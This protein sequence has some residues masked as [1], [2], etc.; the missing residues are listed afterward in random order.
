MKT[1]EINVLI[2]EGDL[3]KDNLDDGKLRRVSHFHDHGDDT[4]SVY[5]TDGGV[6]GL[7]EIS[8]DDIE[9]SWTDHR[10]ALA[11]VAEAERGDIEPFFSPAQKQI[12]N[13]ELFK[14]LVDDV[15]EHGTGLHPGRVFTITGYQPDKT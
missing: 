4:A 15:E 1:T 3:V 11:L 6:M 9:C 12:L 8:F 5:M 13:P 14:G 7:D 2:F 10:N